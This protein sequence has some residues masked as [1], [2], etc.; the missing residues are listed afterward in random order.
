MSCDFGDGSSL[1]IIIRLSQQRRSL[2][3]WTCHSE[4]EMGD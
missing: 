4:E 2:G 1:E 3:K